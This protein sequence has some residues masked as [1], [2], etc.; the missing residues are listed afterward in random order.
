M[1]EQLK[2]SLLNLYNT[3]A[4]EPAKDWQEVQKRFMQLEVREPMSHFTIDNSDGL[5]DDCL[6]PE[7]DFPGDVIVC[8]D[9]YS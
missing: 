6:P 2:N 4:K 3:I 8:S 1:D 5:F 9:Y 7:P